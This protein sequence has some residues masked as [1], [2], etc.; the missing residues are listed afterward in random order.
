MSTSSVNQARR[1]F[2]TITTAVVGGAGVA[3][4]SVPF[5]KVWNPSSQARALG[6]PVEVNLSKLDVGQMIRIIWRG[7]PVWIVHRSDKNITELQQIRAQLSDPDSQQQQQPTYA[8]NQYRSIYPQYFIAIG[9]CTHLGCAPTYFPQDF[10]QHVQGIHAGFFCPC[11]GS[12]FDMAG[13]VFKDVPAPVN[14]SIPPHYYRDE[15]NL[16]IGIDPDGEA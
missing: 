16:V 14:L 2:L 10:E 8:Q 9:L 13:R 15:Q 6:A 3:A 4:A 11:H 7:Q 1:R 5:F 12:T